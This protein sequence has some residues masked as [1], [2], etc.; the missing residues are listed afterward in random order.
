MTAG[1]DKPGDKQSSRSSNSRH[2]CRLTALWPLQGSGFLPLDFCLSDWEEVRKT[3]ATG[4]SMSVN[5]L[6]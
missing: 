6:E 3:E 1:A 5:V 2:Q 4:P